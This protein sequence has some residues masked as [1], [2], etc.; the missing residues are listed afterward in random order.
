MLQTL[1]LRRSLQKLICHQHKK[2]ISSFR[3]RQKASHPAWPIFYRQNFCVLDIKEWAASVASS[4]SSSLHSDIVF[5]ENDFKHTRKET[6]NEFL[7][8]AVSKIV[9]GKETAVLGSTTQNLLTLILWKCKVFQNTFFIYVDNMKLLPPSPQ[10]LLTE[11]LG[12]R[13]ENNRD[14]EE[15][16]PYFSPIPWVYLRFVRKRLWQW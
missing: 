6:E 12:P 8:Q 13:N 14:E 11:L 4:S 9:K 3:P 1:F 10:T 2:F 5:S 7:L 15:K 16:C